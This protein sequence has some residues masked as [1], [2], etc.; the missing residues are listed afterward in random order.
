MSF[1]AAV[2]EGLEEKAVYPAIKVYDRFLVDEMEQYVYF[3]GKIDIGPSSMQVET[4]AE[5]FTHGDRV[6][7]AALCILGKKFQGI[8][9]IDST[10][11]PEYGTPA[12]RMLEADRKKA[13]EKR[14]QWR[15]YKD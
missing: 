10:I 12:W 1:D 15:F 13:K 3:E 7:A 6:I 8:P 14:E 2:H 11:I 9:D 4:G 5:K